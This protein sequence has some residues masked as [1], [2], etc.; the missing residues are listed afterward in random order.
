MNTAVLTV[1]GLV[2]L[3]A[4]PLLVARLLRR[5][6]MLRSNFRSEV[7]PV[8]FGLV[9]LLWTGP[10]LWL[11]GAAFSTSGESYFAMLALVAGFG[12]LGF[13][14]DRWGDRSATGLRGHIRRLVRERQV[15]T[16]L[17]K[18][19]G[20]A[21]LAY[22]VPCLVLHHRWDKA[23]LEGAVIALSANAFNLLDLRP[24]RAAA[25]FLATSI[26]LVAA[27]WQD[28]S[29]PPLVYVVIPATLVYVLD[30]RARVMLGD[31]G[32]NAL[33]AAIGGSIIL[34][35]PTTSALWGSLAALTA[36]HVAAE[37]WSLTKIIESNALLS[38]MD[39]LTGVR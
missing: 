35:A 6:G 25:I 1:T 36:L 28:S 10:A 23:L 2:W 4:L 38:S 29:A 12:L 8:G 19:A 24:G 17:V 18:M 20:G 7:I 22:L 37:R 3:I 5:T 14:D 39:R 15:T 16:G 34:L 32:S 31:T 21:L 26:P 9:I 27:G 30:A 33:G 11:A 13:V